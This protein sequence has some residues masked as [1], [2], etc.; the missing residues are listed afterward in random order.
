[1]TQSINHSSIMKNCLPILVL[2]HRE[3]IISINIVKFMD[4]FQV[5]ISHRFKGRYTRKTKSKIHCKKLISTVLWETRNKKKSWKWNPSINKTNDNNNTNKQDKNNNNKKTNTTH[6][7]YL[8]QSRKINKLDVT[9][10]C[11][12]AGTYTW[13]EKSAPGFCIACRSGCNKNFR[14]PTPP[15]PAP[16]A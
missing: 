5:A 10:N 1:M 6:V 13:E 11:L 14:P 12:L 7:V 2:E 3:N 8:S 16:I 15:P 4:S 9:W